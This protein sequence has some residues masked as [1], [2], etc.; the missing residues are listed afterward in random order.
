MCIFGV[1]FPA[2]NHTPQHTHAVVLCDPWFATLNFSEN[3]LPPVYF[4]PL[5][6]YNFQKFPTPPFIWH[7]RVP[8]SRPVINRIFIPCPTQATKTPTLSQ[9]KCKICT[10]S[11]IKINNLY[12]KIPIRIP[13]KWVL[14]FDRIEQ[15]TTVFCAARF[16]NTT[17]CVGQNCCKTCCHNNLILFFATLQHLQFCSIKQPL[18][19]KSHS[20]L[21]LKPNV[22]MGDCC[23]MHKADCT[24]SH[25]F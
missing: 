18:C 12:Q 21:L 16:H 15:H 1:K 8:S 10:L 14:N 25:P 17:L 13:G 19:S 22:H 11:Q 4:Y 23:K 5:V 7:L 9:N 20:V 24:L 6:Y 2:K 3:S